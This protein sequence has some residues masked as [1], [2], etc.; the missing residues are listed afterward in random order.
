MEFTNWRDRNQTC[1]LCRMPAASPAEP[2]M[3][4]C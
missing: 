1:N 3:V 2:L 4:W